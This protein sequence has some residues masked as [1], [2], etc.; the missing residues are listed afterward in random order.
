MLPPGP[1]GL[2]MLGNVFQLGWANP[3]V[4]FARLA[5]KHGAIMTIRLGMMTTVVISSKDVAREMFKHHDVV[6]AGR[7][8]YESMK[9]RKGNEGSLITAQYGSHWRMLRRLCASEFFVTSRLDALKGVRGRCVSNMVRYVQEASEGGANSIDIGRY[10]FLM[11]FNLLGNLMF[12]KDLLDPNSEQGAAFFYHAGKVMELAWKPNVADF[13]PGLRWLDP[14]G[15]RKKTQ[16]HVEQAFNIAGD[17]IK[18]RMESKMNG[19]GGEQKKDFLNVLLDFQGNGTEEPAFTA[20]TINILVLEMF[21]AGTDSTSG[22][23]EWALA[24]L[25][26]HPKAMK[27]VQDELREVVQSYRELEENDLQNLPYLRAVMKETLRLHPPLPFL[28]PHMAMDSC[29][30]L[31]YRIPKETQV[32]VNVWAIGRDPE[33]WKDPSVFTPERFLEMDNV[34]YKGHNFEYLPFG[35]GRRMC[36]AIPLASRVLPLTLGSLLHSF[37][38]VLPDGLK[39]ECMDMTEKMGITLRKA[40]PLNVIPVPYQGNNSG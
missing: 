29:R 20:R 6:L 26:R 39:P 18:Q 27:K 11:S 5:S 30:M 23:I 28:I 24:E 3:H 14:Q 40:V 36:P 38:W 31:G 22:T 16:H 8:I 13:L 21:I 19:A 15:L 32:L 34:D 4:S 25:I 10:I 35:S 12:S 17:F 2:P 1:R 7:K 9:G 33:T 37:N